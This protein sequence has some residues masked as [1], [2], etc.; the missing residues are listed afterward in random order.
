MFRGVLRATRVALDGRNR[1]PV[2]IKYTQTRKRNDR[3]RLKI[4]K[5]NAAIIR[6]GREALTKRLEREK[7]EELTASTAARPTAVPSS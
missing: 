4:L 1:F 5:E 6:E 7:M 2:N 3:K